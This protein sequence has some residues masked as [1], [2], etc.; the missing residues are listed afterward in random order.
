MRV[1]VFSNGAGLRLSDES[2]DEG[3]LGE[4]VRYPLP[5]E[6]IGKTWEVAPEQAE[7]DMFED[8]HEDSH[9]RGERIKKLAGCH[10]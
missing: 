4:A 10:V 3:K 5:K 6:V 9:R 2:P 8:D 1:V 7:P